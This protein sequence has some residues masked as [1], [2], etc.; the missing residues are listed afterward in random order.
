MEVYVLIVL[1]FS[2]LMLWRILKELRKIERKL[3]H[4]DERS[5]SERFW[6]NGIKKK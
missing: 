4:P 1:V 6:G 3:T 5:K 2:H